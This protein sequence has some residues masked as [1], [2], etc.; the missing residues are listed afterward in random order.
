VDLD[1]TPQYAKMWQSGFINPEDGSD[2]LLRNISGLL[3]D[4]T[5]LHPRK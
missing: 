2:M 5:A 4:Y 1:S 3:T